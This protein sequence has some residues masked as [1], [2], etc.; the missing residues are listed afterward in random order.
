MGFLV[1]V[2]LGVAKNVVLLFRKHPERNQNGK[3]FAAMLPNI[4][5]AS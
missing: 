3:R 1:G 4:L 2:D 5:S